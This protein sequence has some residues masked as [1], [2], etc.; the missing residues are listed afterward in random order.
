MF[1]LKNPQQIPCFALCRLAVIA[2][3]VM[4]Q[5]ASA[6][7]VKLDIPSRRIFVP[8]EELD[9]VIERDKKGVLLPQ[10]ELKTLLELAAKNPAL[11]NPPPSAQLVSKCDYAARIVGD[12]LLLTVTA[13]LQQ[14]V[15]GWQA[16]TFPLQRLAVEKAT[17]NNEPAFV[18]RHDDGALTLLTS[19]EGS[20]V[21]K[22]ELSTEIVTLGSDQAIAFSLV[23]SPAGELTITL[24]A[25]KRLLLD[26]LQ[27]ERPA[28]IDQP[29]DYK[30]AIGGRPSLQLRITDRATDRKA[31]ALVFATTG[32]GLFV[33]PGEVTWHA[34]TT[35]QVFGRPVDR[36]VCSVPGYLEIADV[37]ATG[38]ES[39]TLTDDPANPQ[40]T[41]I[42]LTFGQPLDGSRK[43]TFR[44]VMPAPAGTPWLAPPLTIVDATSHV[45]QV[46]LQY[47]VGVRLQI[48]EMDGIRRATVGQKS[49]MDM[50]SDMLK[51]NA[52]ETLRF[53]AWQDNFTLRC[54]TQ[55]KPRELH[56]AIAAVVDVASS[57][58]S[59]Q[60]ALTLTP[61]FAPLFDVDV[62]L[63]AEWSV[64]A[65][66]GPDGQ[67][68]KWELVPQA[69]GTS[70]F[71]FAL[72]QPIAPGVEGVVKLELRREV[73]G[74]PVEAEPIAFPLPELVLPQATLAETAIIVRGDNDLDLVAEEFVG[75]DPAPLKA[76]W[77]RLRFQSQD[78]RYSGRLKAIRKP[79]RLAAEVTGVYRL[80]PQTLHS[81]LFASV[82]VEGGGT[83][84]IVVSLPEAV[85]ADIRFE[86]QGLVE[87]Q[88]LPVENGRRRWRLQLAERLHGETFLSTR[89]EM[90][91]PAQGTIAAPVLTVEETDRQFGAVVVEAGPE[92]QLTIEAKDS[93]GL[94]LA[95]TDPLDLPPV[96]YT[97]K[98]R[99][100]G[101]YRTVSAGATL[102]LSEQR[103]DKSAVPTA[104]CRDLLVS[105]IVSKTGEL[106]QKAD[107]QVTLAGVPQLRVKLPEHATLWA[108]LI[109]QQP[110]EVRRQ[111]DFYVLPVATGSGG[112]IEATVTL[113]YRGHVA[114]LE[115]AGTFR[116]SPPEL[117]AVSG[118]GQAEPMEV[119]E[120]RWEVVHPEDT[121]LVFSRGRLEPA[122]A[123]DQPG[124]LARWGDLVRQPT[125]SSAGWGLF[126]IVITAGSLALALLL[127]QRRGSRGLIEAAFVVSGL[128]CASFCIFTFTGTQSNEKFATS[129]HGVESASS[130]SAAPTHELYS[131]DSS[132]SGGT[133]VGLAPPAAA[134]V[135]SPAPNASDEFAPRSE[136]SDFG[137]PMGEAKSEDTPVAAARRSLA[138]SAKDREERNLVKRRSG[139]QL[140]QLQGAAPQRAAVPQIVPA[141]PNAAKEDRAGNRQSQEEMKQR[142]K[143]ILGEVQI[144]NL[145]ALD[146][147]AMEPRHGSG[148]AKGKGLLSLSLALEAPSH[149][150]SKSFRYLGA[151]SGGSGDAL[152]LDY[153]DRNAGSVWRLVLFALGLFGGWV[154]RKAAV[155]HRVAALAVLLAVS[156]GL[157]PVAPVA[158][159]VTL[160]GLFGLACGAALSWGVYWLV[161]QCVLKCRHCCGF[162]N[163]AVLL[164]VLLTGASAEAQDQAVKPVAPPQT[165][166]RPGLVIPFN[167]EQDPKTADR[168]LLPF[169]KFV[170]LYQL[171]HPEKNIQTP[172]P[173]AGRI[174][175]ALY[176]AELSVP[177]KQPEAASVKLKARLVLR[178]YVDGQFP[179]VLPFSGVALNAA[180]LNDKPAAIKVD[181][182]HLTLLVPAAG[183]HVLDIEFSVPAK[184]LG[185]AGSFHLALAPTPAAQLSFALPSEKLGVRVNG[186]TTAYRR[187]T[188]NEKA[189]V[190]LPI[191]RGGDLQISWQPEQTREGGA[192]VVHVESV[193][194]VSVADA[195]VTVSSGFKYRVR[196]GIVRDVA[197]ALPEGVKLQG[198]NGPDVGGWELVGDGAQRRLRVFLRRNVGDGTELTIDTYLAHRVEATAS[199]FAVA[200]IAPLEVTTEVG[201]VVV[202]AGEQFSVRP[203]GVT[204]LAQV[205]TANYQ[206]VVPVTRIDVPAQLVYRFSRRPWTL[207]LTTSRLTSQMQVTQLQGQRITD[208]KVE[209]TTRVSCDLSLVPRSALDLRVPANWVVLDVQSQGL[210]DWFLTP[211]DNG[212]A[213]LTLEYDQPRQGVVEI[214][215]LTTQSRDPAQAAVAL[216]SLSVTGA[217]RVQRQSAVWLDTGLNA[218]VSSLDKWKTLDIAALDP[219]FQHLQPVGAQLAFESSQVDPGDVTLTLNRATPRLMGESLTSITVTDV[220]VVYGFVFQWKIDQ[221]TADRLIIDTPAELAGKLD[222]QGANLR[223]VAT[224]VLPDG[225]LRWTLALRSP[226]MGAFKLTASAT[227]PPQTA[228]I[229]AP[230]LTFIGNDADAAPLATQRHYV[231]LVN[232]SLNQLTATDATVREPVQRE[233]VSIVVRKELTDQAT[234]FVRVKT[235]GTGLAWTVQRYTPTAGIPASVNLADITMILARDG[236]YRMQ[237][238]YTLKNRSRQFLAIKLPND[239][240]LLS[241]FVGDQASRTV[242]TKLKEEEIHLIALPKTGAAD[243]SFRVALTLSGR[244]PKTLPLGS[245]VMGRDLDLPSPMIVGQEESLEFGIPVA[246]TRWA[247]Y[248]PDDLDVWPVRD[249]KRNNLNDQAPNVAD[250]YGTR[251]VLQDYAELLSNYDLLSS[252]RSRF[253]CANNLKQLDVVLQTQ[254]PAVNGGDTALTEEYRKLQTRYQSIVQQQQQQLP[255][256]QSRAEG[257][258]INVN[259]NGKPQTQDVQMQLDNAI[260]NNSA[261]FFDNGVNNGVNGL[262]FGDTN[263][264]IDGKPPV[265]GFNFTV[266]D[267]SKSMAPQSKS[268]EKAA[269]EAQ[270]SLKNSGNL[271]ARNAYRSRNEDQLM[272][273]NREIS[274][275][276]IAGQQGQQGQQGQPGGFGFQGQQGRWSALGQQGQQGQQGLTQF[277]RGINGNGVNLPQQPTNLSGTANPP[278]SGSGTISTNGAMA[279][280]GPMVNGPGPGIIANGDMVIDGTVR[281]NQPFGNTFGGA[282]GGG[283][284]GRMGGLGRGGAL[285]VLNVEQDGD[286]MVANPWFDAEAGQQVAFATGW[287]Q[288]GG[289]SLDMAL[290]T[291]GQKLVFAKSGGDAKLALVLRP[292][293]A[294]SLSLGLVWTVFCIALAAVCL[295]SGRNPR[296]RRAVPVLIAGLA[297]IGV[298]VLAGPLSGLAFVVFVIAAAKVAWTYRNAAAV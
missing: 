40:R 145:A 257:L 77:E 142:I 115:N 258:Q 53:D 90:P 60:A 225:R 244:L 19:K 93:Q 23:G 217:V 42:T 75:L 272:D 181:G 220:A 109:N 21:L 173:D 193:S 281:L 123:L 131:R 125:W 56:A 8:A 277:N 74:W 91:R 199:T 195:G 286:G 230:G 149:S 205:D 17:L 216:G 227:L 184:V 174:I 148:L 31:D 16:W 11:K 158:W 212:Q 84:R 283:F 7:D 260:S 275:K 62:Q 12:H 242:K 97:P 147:F 67:P 208:R 141:K 236:S 200:E 71:R 134:P 156:L 207:Q 246:R 72:R 229:V 111:D 162:F 278:L 213:A 29:A 146:P 138:A 235:A 122:T 160:D 206:P 182:G 39:W 139:L 47:P 222:F 44:G 107:F 57:G 18:G 261:L 282:G 150:R 64:V 69:A 192:A 108:A 250:S 210:K 88:P 232:T 256:V 124:W 264:P 70:Q 27:R 55:P 94:P 22:L 194:A 51:A 226:V 14:L 196:Q 102:T 43:I 166:Q 38:L 118:Q 83:R 270:Q 50:P 132:P 172:P 92:Q 119:L 95:E 252:E 296:F 177:E 66:T 259:P 274:G 238:A 269:V 291:S 49:I 96:P 211:G 164:T 234:E 9:V 105:S 89:F 204:G 165:V 233:D 266:I 168:V 202:Y 273:L 99:I 32:Y 178:S 46:V 128:M 179:V 140:E 231:L 10:A 1:F 279:L 68:L 25:G 126:V 2:F 298:V 101:A 288:T 161:S 26:G 113:F 136:L 289:L 4:L 33:T 297:A 85:G 198:V 103:F 285:G 120:Q 241:V 121:L 52:A 117:T 253:L 280:P 251:A 34:L 129:I 130:F 271:D 35:L 45:G 163:A 144:D 3:L 30:V 237:A 262:R 203:E 190:E 188:Q 239:S 13:D 249:A 106:Q 276:K 112:A 65:A 116:Q 59:L 76:E 243:L 176:R 228:Q 186:S 295:L 114:A 61:R 171:A 263:G 293:R 292:R 247:V 191:D 86:L 143:G 155:T 73:D 254:S 223:D 20:Y 180:K 248:V 133:L 219:Q 159:Q 268:A 183:L 170:E 81:E 284:G 48:Q 58:L 154:T 201:H 78:T 221:A 240:R 110:V 167:A 87:Q 175:E 214:V 24:P 245:Q 153:V 15:P 152:E 169:E 82:F 100:V 104:V 98:E 127:Y 41:L 137:R 189:S 151:A 224:V 197:F 28:A 255:A 5:S 294:L 265:Q 63:P 6:S 215:V 157:S 37:E 79:A 54:L 185:A 209:T 287:K 36:V 135:T 290:P 267:E 187:I 80:D 218:Q